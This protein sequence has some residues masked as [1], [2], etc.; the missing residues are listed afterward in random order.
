MRKSRDL[1]REAAMGTGCKAKGF[2]M[3]RLPRSRA[4]MYSFGD[5]P[6]KAVS[7]A[8]G[9]KG[10]VAIR[11]AQ[12]IHCGLTIDEKLVTGMWFG[13]THPRKRVLERG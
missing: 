10:I 4:P 1:L 2:S 5:K 8:R 12:L 3:V 6:S 11:N 7:G 13:G 9:G